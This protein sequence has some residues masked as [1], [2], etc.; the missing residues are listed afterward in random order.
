MTKVGTALSDMLCSGVVQGSSIGP[1]MFPVYINESIYLLEQH[2][3]K[4]KMFADDVKIYLKIIN[5]VHIVQLLLS[6]TSLV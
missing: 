3:I 1:L 6:L 4:V 2:N 5:D